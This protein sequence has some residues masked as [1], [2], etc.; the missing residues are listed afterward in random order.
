MK[1]GSWQHHRH[2]ENFFGGEYKHV[3]KM[4]LA[5]H[6]TF[7]WKNFPTEES[8]MESFNLSKKDILRE[9]TDQ[10]FLLSRCKVMFTPDEVR[11]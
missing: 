10:C 7:I 2:E 5:M 1:G 4:I 11:N 8:P 6:F 9:E 3:F